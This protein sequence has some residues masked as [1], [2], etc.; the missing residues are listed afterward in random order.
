MHCQSTLR[1]HQSGIGSYLSNSALRE[2]EKAEPD[3]ELKAFAKSSPTS[4]DFFF[5]RKKERKT[6][7][8]KISQ[9]FFA[10]F[11]MDFVA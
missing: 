6:R 2:E 10:C 1:E 5:C 9:R 7:E 11:R 8:K 3:G 4:E